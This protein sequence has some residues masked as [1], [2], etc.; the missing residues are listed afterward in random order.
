[1]GLPS[2]HLPFTQG[3]KGLPVGLQIVGRMGQDHLLL[4]AAAQLHQDLRA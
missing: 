1:M 2:V 4:Q 3:A